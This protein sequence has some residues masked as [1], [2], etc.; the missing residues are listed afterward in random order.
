[1]GNSARGSVMPWRVGRG[2]RPKRE[3]RYID[4]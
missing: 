3:A 2:G 4:R 1:M